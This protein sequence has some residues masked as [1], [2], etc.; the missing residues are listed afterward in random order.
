MRS[1]RVVLAVIALALPIQMQAQSP[2]RGVIFVEALRA[3]GCAV[4]P[5]EL[6][7][8]LA[9]TGMTDGELAVYAEM[10]EKSDLALFSRSGFVLS[11]RL[12]AAS[13]AELQTYVTASYILKGGFD[14]SALATARIF[15]TELRRMGCV[16]NDTWIAGFLNAHGLAADVYPG[17]IE[18]MKTAGIMVGADGFIGLADEYCTAESPAV[19]DMLRISLQ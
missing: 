16:A 3:N 17:F 8:V 13:A 5:R 10:L 1:L 2:D 9:G 15:T 12:C 18:Q 19:L 14:Y 4:T 7:S 6:G 11:Q